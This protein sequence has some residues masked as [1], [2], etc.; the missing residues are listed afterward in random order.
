MTALRA[1]SRPAR[2]GTV[3]LVG[4]GPGDPG[5]LTV[6]ALEL[7]RNADVILHNHLVSAEILAEC[8]Y[9]ARIIDVGKVGHG[10]QA[11]Q[12]VIE[13]HLI[14]CARA[15][16]SVVRLKRGDPLLFGRGSEEA[17]ALRAAAVPFEIV[18]GVSRPRLR[19]Q[20]TREFR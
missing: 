13:R 14:A 5:L 9:H 17:A 20:P 2:P 19:R 8:G 18:P 16:R 4:A 3:D 12:T 6:R 10:P 1:D 11:D 15:G 7:I